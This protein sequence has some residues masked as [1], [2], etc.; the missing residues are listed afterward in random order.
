MMITRR[1]LDVRTTREPEFA[2][3]IGRIRGKHG[4]K[5]DEVTA[6]SEITSYLLLECGSTDAVWIGLAY[7]EPGDVSQIDGG[8]RVEFPPFMMG[9]RNESD[10]MSEVA[11]LAEER[12]ITASP[13][14]KFDLHYTVTAE[15]DVLD[16]IEPDIIAALSPDRI[17]P[18]TEFDPAAEAA[19]IREK[20]GVITEK[21][22]ETLPKQTGF[23]AQAILR[24]PFGV[25][26][27]VMAFVALAVL[28]VRS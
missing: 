15:E 17:E 26:A 19:R 11:Q 9:G 23:L 10:V 14:R 25:S 4:L 7:Q 16:L 13:T 8:I 20:L 28:I 21:D 3:T 6:R 12:G 5:T 18:K 1:Y 22:E 2:Q 24:E 27:F